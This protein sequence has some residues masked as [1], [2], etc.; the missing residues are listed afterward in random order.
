VVRSPADALLDPRVLARGEVEPLKHPTY[1][2]VGEAYGPGLPITFSDAVAD[3]DQPP[4]WM[5]E[6]NRLVYGERLGYSEER[7]ARLKAEGAI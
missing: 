3:H 4:P 7:L 2:A 1:G 5:G 6:H